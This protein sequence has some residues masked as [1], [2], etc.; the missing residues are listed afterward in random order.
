MNN[1]DF[2]TVEEFAGILEAHPN[3]VYRSIKK[4]HISAFRIGHGIRS[5]YRIPQSEINRMAEFNL[6]EIIQK[7]VE[8][9]M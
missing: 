5:S 4:G 9:R 8:K 3:T 2:Y 7:E 1:K 6:E